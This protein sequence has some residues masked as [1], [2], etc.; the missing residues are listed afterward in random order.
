MMIAFFFFLFSVTLV[1]R[2]PAGGKMPDIKKVTLRDLRP[3]LLSSLVT[4][5]NEIG[6]VCAGPSSLPSG[7]DCFLFLGLMTSRDRASSFVHRGLLQPLAAI[8]VWTWRADTK[9]CR[10]AEMRFWIPACDPVKAK[11][12]LVL[13]TQ[14]GRVEAPEGQTLPIQRCVLPVTWHPPLEP[15]HLLYDILH[16]QD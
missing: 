16:K 9:H 10:V 8:V 13:S 12:A 3:L 15:I 1:F 2:N 5:L 14:A 7:K 6:S 11:W 4:L